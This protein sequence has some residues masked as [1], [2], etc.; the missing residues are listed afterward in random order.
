[1]PESPKQEPATTTTNT[2]VDE[3]PISPSRNVARRDSLADRLK[4]RPDRAELAQ[5]NI[6]PAFFAPDESQKS[7]LEDHLRHRP[8]RAQLVER[9]I[10]PEG[11]VSPSLMQHQQ[12]LKKHMR[13]DSLNEKISHR[14]SPEKLVES[15]VLHED[16]R[17]VEE[18][19]ADDEAAEGV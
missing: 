3:T 5:R 8:E 7:S 1:M 11:A 19:K 18:K 13:A 12:E 4:H 14:P 9:G 16:P 15:G 17:S 2:F 10:L 6:I